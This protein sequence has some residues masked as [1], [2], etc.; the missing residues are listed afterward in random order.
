MD[1]IVGAIYGNAIGD[2]LGLATEFMTKEE[3]NKHYGE[4]KI[5]YDAIVQDGHR[6]RWKKG[7]WTDDTDQMILIMQT[8]IE[9]DK[10]SDKTSDKTTDKATDNAEDDNAEDDKAEDDNQVILVFQN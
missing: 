7:D 8:I 2:A 5:T 6:R 3:V 4:K 9:T 1:N 10:T